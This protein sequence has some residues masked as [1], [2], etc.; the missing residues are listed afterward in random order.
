MLVAAFVFAMVA[1]PTRGARS[2]PAV[3]LAAA[4]LL[5]LAGAFAQAA[6]AAS[7]TTA[8]VVRQIR[9]AHG[10]AALIR[11]GL[12]RADRRSFAFAGMSAPLANFTALVAV[13]HGGA[14]L[15]GHQSREG[16]HAVILRCGP[17]GAPPGV[18]ASASFTTRPLRARDPYTAHAL[19]LAS[20]TEGIAALGTPADL[21]YLEREA[22][23]I[24]EH[25]GAS[26]YLARRPRCALEVELRNVTRALVVEFGYAPGRE[27]ARGVVVPPGSGGGRV[28]DLPCGAMWMRLS[29]GARCA[30]PAAQRLFTSPAAPVA[31]AVCD[32]TW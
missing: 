12:Q 6:A 23:F 29:P 14:S 9:R 13:T 4:T 17:R 1:A 32:V 2:A 16:I 27:P 5:A 31:R 10:A 19:T 28:G 8:A 30:D 22:G 7:A 18:D 15:Q 21:D 25:R 11:V 3:A 20:L 26:L 24:T